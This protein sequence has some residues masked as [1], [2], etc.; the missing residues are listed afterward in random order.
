MLFRLHASFVEYDNSK[1]NNNDDDDDDDG[2]EF[3]RGNI[4]RNRHVNRGNTDSA[5]YYC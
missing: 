1:T 3:I 2:N 5:R 4:K